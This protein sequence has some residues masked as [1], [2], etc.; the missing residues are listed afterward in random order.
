MMQRYQTTQAGILDILW[1]RGALSR[2]DLAHALRVD[3][4]TISNA[5]AGLLE[6]GII[7][8]GAG[9]EAGPRGGRKAVKLSI[10]PSRACAGGLE[11]QPDGIASALLDL[12]GDAIAS[13]KRRVQVGPESFAEI[14]AQEIE[15]LARAAESRGSRLA[16]IGVGL[17]GIVDCERGAV[18]QS[19]PLRIYGNSAAYGKLRAEFPFDIAFEN[20]V[21]CGAWG[22]L[23]G[24]RAALLD[25][26]L[27]VLVEFR[28]DV[29]RREG[30]SGIS[31]GF[32]FVIDGE[33]RRGKHFQAGEFR[34]LRWKEGNASQF[35]LGDA[36]SFDVKGGGPLLERF[37]DELCEHIALFVNT[38]G[39]ERVILAGDLSAHR[40]VAAAKLADA[41]RRNWS[42][43]AGGP[44]VIAFPEATENAAAI[45]AASMALW[46]LF[47]GAG[48][49]VPLLSPP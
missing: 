40:D 12:A 14:V 25:D 18:V 34:S 49:L 47:K 44:C 48:G 8:E 23:C 39:F 9:G 35:S 10:V 13:W 31:A 37:L 41:I 33:P 29:E 27:Y 42:Y 2:R 32:A 5:A 16:G 3:K 38:M 7:K 1:T 20:D 30:R 28:D 46:R 4:S 21:R 45:G 36:E 6:A 19:I 24:Q 15:G 11:V 26:F 17:S 43:P 22:E